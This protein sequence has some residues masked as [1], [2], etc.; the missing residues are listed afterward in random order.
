MRVCIISPS[1]LGM[2][3]RAVKEA[4]A[5]SQAGHDVTVI[6]TRLAQHVEAGDQDILRGAGWRTIRLDFS[7]PSKR[8]FPRLRQMVGRFLFALTGSLWA[9]KLGNHF[10]T[11]ELTTEALKVPADLYIAHYVAALPAAAMA[12]AVHGAPYAF[13]A[14]DFHIGE[15]P[16]EPRFDIDRRM[17]GVIE[18]RY[19]PK[20]A[21]VSADADGTANAYARVYGIPTPITVLN[22]FPLSHAPASA[23]AASIATPGPSV[24][25]FS[26]T[27]G[28]DRG[29][30]CLVRA[31]G[32]TK[33]RPHL[34]IRGTPSRGYEE[35]LRLIAR[36]A[37]VEDHIHLL[38]PDVAAEMERLASEYD[39][40][41][42]GEPGQSE[43]RRVALTNKIFTYLLA[44]I[45][46][47]ASDIPAH[48]ALVPVM[49]DSMHLFKAEDSQSLA[50]VLDGLL[51]NPA[52][53]KAARKTAWRLGQEQFNWDV[54]RQ[55]LLTAV[56]RAVLPTASRSEAQ[57]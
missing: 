45:A 15:L 21:Y 17:I 53:L 49:G 41:F 5:L 47:I 31:V 56:E 25:W 20:C 35:V 57:Q 10:S 24:Y 51:L 34:Y 11:P 4:Q 30:E 3:P 1:Q 19:L 22:V 46:V 37:G 14:E 55:V 42:V 39:I 38:P 7:V 40:G 16:E 27:I 32:R 9:A 29:L 28:T 54:E 26:Q 6:A 23:P 2:N 33:S 12:A 48:L 44:G 18:G 43:S 13:D 8:R 36:E 50:D 52:A